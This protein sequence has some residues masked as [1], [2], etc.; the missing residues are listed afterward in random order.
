MD[1]G[2]IYDIAIVGAGPAGLTAAIYAGRANKSVIIL[3]KEGIGGQMARS[4]KI[5]NYPG[6]PSIS[7][8][9]LACKLSE[10]AEALGARLDFDTVTSVD[11]DGDIKVLKG[12]YGEYRARSVIIASG[13]KHR[14]LGLADEDEHPISYCAVCDGAFYSGKRVCVVGGGNSALQEALHLADV[15]ANVTVIQN[16]AT[17]TGESKLISKLSQLKN[18]NV[19]FNTVVEGI[20]SDGEQIT[21]ILLSDT[22]H[23]THTRLETDG[24]FVAIG[25]IPENAPF[26]AVCSLDAQGYIASNESCNTQTPGVFV[27]G[28]CRAKTI[29]QITTAT[30]DGTVAAVAA[31]RYL[32]GQNS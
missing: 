32:D 1:N 23:G 22:A 14:T 9:E 12:E 28:D 27:A 3:E 29:R 13:S 21:S 8:N 26:T 10:Q 20:E 11:T 16:L 2:N 15:C 25:L 18:V 6:F 4:P 17:L 24:L 5:E 7:G 31:C 19:I 30:A